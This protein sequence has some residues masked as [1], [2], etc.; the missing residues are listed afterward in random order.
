MYSIEKKTS[1]FLLTFGGVID[2]AE[3]QKW[4][5]ESERALSSAQAPFGVIIDMRTLKPLSPDAQAVMV[6][7]QGLYKTKGMQRSAVILNDAVTTLQFKR[8][9]QQSGIYAFERY[10]DASKTSDWTKVAVEWVKEGADPDK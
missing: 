6:Q 4:L 3:M 2:A 10:I 1:G 8:L 9:A 7:G 5:A